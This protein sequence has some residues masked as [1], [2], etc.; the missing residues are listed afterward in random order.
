M[1]HLIWGGAAV[2]RCDKWLISIVALAAAV[3]LSPSLRFYLEELRHIAEFLIARLKQ[4]PDRQPLYRRQMLL[5]RSVKKLR[6]LRMVGMRASR[7]LR[8]DA[9]DA[10]Q[11]V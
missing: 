7:K 5:Q 9:I 3:T 4:L 8:D 1:S 11:L 10:A 2:H 6:C